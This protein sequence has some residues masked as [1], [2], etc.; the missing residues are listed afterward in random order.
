MGFLVVPTA[1][2]PGLAINLDPAALAL[3]PLLPGFPLFLL[4]TGNDIC[5]Y[6]MG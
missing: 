6:F 4:F 3:G 1:L 5:N 2:A